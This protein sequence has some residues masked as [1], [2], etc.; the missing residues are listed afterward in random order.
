MLLID[1]PNEYI[2]IDKP[3]ILD[4]NTILR[5][6]VDD[7]GNPLTII[8]MK[9]C[10]HYPIINIDNDKEN[11][12]VE[13]IIFIGNGNTVSREESDISYVIKNNCINIRNSKNVMINNCK[14]HNANSGGIVL[15]YCNDIKIVNCDC[16]YNLI[17]GIA[18]FS[19]EN[20]FIDKCKINGN[21][22]SGVSI[23]ALY[24]ELSS[25]IKIKDSRIVNNDH[26]SIWIRNG[27]VIQIDNNCLDSIKRENF[28]TKK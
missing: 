11:I 8:K 22:Y 19:S 16:S 25:L 23:D 7:N 4:S 1:L 17:D 10:V 24:M 6:K 21:K 3:L 12:I 13:N 2:L 9:D 18:V 5:G 26:F 20:I 15:A 27:L 14:T 28:R